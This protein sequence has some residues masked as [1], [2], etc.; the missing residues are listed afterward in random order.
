[1]SS[2]SA[3]AEAPPIEL[4]RVVDDFLRDMLGTFPEYTAAVQTWWQLQSPRAEQI[5]AVQMHLVARLTPHFFAIMHNQHADVLGESLAATL[6][7][8][9]DF[10]PGLDFR[11]LW[12]DAGMTEASQRSMWTHLQLMQMALM[13]A[14][15]GDFAAQFFDTDHVR[16]MMKSIQEMEFDMSPEMETVLQEA[17]AMDDIPVMDDSDSDSESESDTAAAAA[18]ASAAAPAMD[19]EFDD[20][21]PPD[22]EAK[23]GESPADWFKTLMSGKMKGKL[24]KLMKGSLGRVAKQMMD[25]VVREMDA[26]SAEELM[27]RVQSDTTLIK[28]MFVCFHNQL[29]EALRNKQLGAKQLAEGVKFFKSIV[30]DFPGL[31]NMVK[32]AMAKM[33]VNMDDVFSAATG[34][35]GGGGSAAAFQETMRKEGVA[36]DIRRRHEQRVRKQMEKQMQAQAAAA[37]AAQQQS[38]AMSEEDLIAYFA[39]N[40]NSNNNN[41]N[42]KK[43]STSREKK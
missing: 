28:P 9:T 42:K 33:G 31:Q 15:A 21:F 20:L 41:S 2:S 10:L 14:E 7:H 1:M 36:A 23:A 34:A 11:V 35:G 39:T 24:D 6:S 16:E 13:P 30:K 5:H 32:T 22:A 27:S 3:N 18:A 19:D 29:K 37:V 4:A 17:M 43:K 26:S 40:S 12:F 8:A 25:A 38:Q